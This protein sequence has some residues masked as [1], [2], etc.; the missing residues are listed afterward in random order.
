MPWAL[1]SHPQ[2]HPNDGILQ[3]KWAAGATSYITRGC[4][5]NAGP[6]SATLARYGASVCPACDAG[7][8]AVSGTVLN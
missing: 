6:A 8:L 4:W 1:T 5:R 3:L 2:P 7:R